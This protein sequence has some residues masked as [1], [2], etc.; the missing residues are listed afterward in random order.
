MSY[1]L[2]R[3]RVLRA[4]GVSLAL[5]LLDAFT[6]P[7]VRAASA[8]PPR[9]LEQ[10]HARLHNARIELLFCKYYGRFFPIFIGFS[11]ARVLQKDHQFPPQPARGQTNERMKTKCQTVNTSFTQLAAP[12]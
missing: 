11:M 9:K 6:S 10:P 1:R 5:P 3:R 8:T 12:G 7:R 4:A 2:N